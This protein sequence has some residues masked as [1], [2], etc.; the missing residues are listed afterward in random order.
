MPGRPQLEAASELRDF[1]RRTPS[2]TTAM[3]AAG[4]RPRD[5]IRAEIEA[6]GVQDYDEDEEEDR[7][8]SPTVSR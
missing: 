1:R 2:A 7:T 3:Q 8:R 5:E 4:H 6:R